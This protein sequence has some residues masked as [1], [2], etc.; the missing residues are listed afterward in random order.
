MFETSERTRGCIKYFSFLSFVLCHN[1]LYIISALCLSTWLLWQTLQWMLHMWL[2]HLW[3]PIR[4]IQAPY[5]ARLPSSSDLASKGF[6]VSRRRR[7]CRCQ[8]QLCPAVLLT[9]SMC[10]FSKYHFHQTQFF[11]FMRAMCLWNWLSTLIHT[12][13]LYSSLWNIYC[14]A[15]DLWKCG[16]CQISV[17]GQRGSWLAQCFPVH[18]WMVGGRVWKV[19]SMYCLGFTAVLAWSGRSRG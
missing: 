3:G 4:D 15:N 16:E 2:F 9:W 12:S 19:W 5:T 7:Q 17:R 8:C 14:C 1:H 18:V 13:P 11:Y 10:Y 6:F